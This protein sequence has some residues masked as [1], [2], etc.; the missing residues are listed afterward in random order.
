MSMRR[1]ARRLCALPIL[2]WKDSP[3]LG[4]QAVMEGVMMRNG[5]VYGLAVRR[6]DGG[7]VA[8]RRPWFSLLRWPWI[9]MPFLRGFPTLMETLING[10]K[11]LNRSAEQAAESE[12]GELKGWHLLATLAL[13]MSM[14]VLLFV[15]TPHLMSVGMQWL[16]L[17]GDVNGLSFHLW[18]GLFKL[19]IFIGYILAI[20]LLPD[21]RRVFQYHGAEHKVI[22][23]FESGGEV[24]AVEAGRMSR[25]HARCGTTF[26]LFVVSISIVLHAALVPALLLLWTPQ[27]VVVKHA[28]AIGFKLLLMLPISSLAYELIRYAARLGDGFWGR[29]L[30]AP[31][32]LLQLLTTYEP[33]RDQLEVAVAALHEALGP[34]APDTVRPADYRAME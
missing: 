15:V 7:I 27:S 33:E 2:F 13:S 24:T 21:I 4:G 23:A 8:E 18:D 28:A 14:A 19:L 30:R 6:A 11:A 12:A 17:G 31:G 22:H 1:I 16:G 29:T 26:L 32:L 20:S 25:L 5:D 10:V 9:K 34:H 3:L